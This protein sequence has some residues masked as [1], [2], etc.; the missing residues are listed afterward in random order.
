MYL[1]YSGTYSIIPASTV[2]GPIVKC[3][4]PQNAFAHCNDAPSHPLPPP[5]HTQARAIG[6]SNYCQSCFECLLDGA[7]V[8]PAVN[9]VRD[10]GREHKNT[11]RGFPLCSMCVVIICTLYVH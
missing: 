1:S 8:V 5:T 2:V 7:K 10:E 3:L 9:Q 4:D 6:V 11:E